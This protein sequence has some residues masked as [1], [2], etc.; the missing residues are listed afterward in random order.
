MKPRRRHQMR[1][2]AIGSV[3]FCSQCHCADRYEVRGE[4]VAAW[5]SHLSW[6]DPHAPPESQPTV[7]FLIKVMDIYMRVWHFASHQI[8]VKPLRRSWFSCHEME[9]LITYSGGVRLSHLRQQTLDKE[10]DRVSPL[11]SIII[12]IIIIIIIIVIS[13]Y[14]HHHQ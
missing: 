1:G 6:C 14:Y 8:Q 10:T 12:V 4:C 5:R 9:L 13:L 7:R 2:W 3:G 11:L